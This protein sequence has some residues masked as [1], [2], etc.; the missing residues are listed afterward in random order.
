MPLPKPRSDE[1]ESKFVSRCMSSDVMK[2]EFPDKEQ[3]AAVCYRQF[4]NSVL[5]KNIK[6]LKDMLS[7]GLGDK[8]KPEDVDPDELAMGIE[9]EM[10]HTTDREIAQEIAIDHLAEIKD[11]Y[12]RLKRMEEEAKNEAK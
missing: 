11:Y 12:S 9:V 6:I 4:R 8:L 1:K 10:E 5:K 3:R 7:G 2:K